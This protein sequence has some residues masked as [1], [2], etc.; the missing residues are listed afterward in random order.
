MALAWDRHGARSLPETAAVFAGSCAADHDA[1]R[2]CV[3]KHCALRKRQFHEV[4]HCGLVVCRATCPDG[5]KRGITSLCSRNA[6]VAEQLTLDQRVASASRC[7]TNDGVPSELP[8]IAILAG[9]RLEPPVAGNYS[10]YRQLSEATSMERIPLAH[11]TLY[12]EL[13]Q[14]ALHAGFD[15]Q[16]PENGSF[17]TKTRKGRKYWYYEGYETTS[18]GVTEARKYSKYVGPQ[19]DPEIAGRVETFG[20]TKASFRER[21]ALVMSLRDA[22]LPTPRA[23]VGDVVEAF[24]KAGLFRL[25]GVLVGTLAYQTYA[26]LLGVRLPAAAVMTGDVD[27]AQSHSVSMLVEDTIPPVLETLQAVDKTFRERPHLGKGAAPAYVND[28]NFSVE[29]LTPNRGG[30]EHAG[31]PARMPALGGASAQPLRYLD[32][33][34]ANPVRAVLLHKGGVLVTVPAPE[35]F[36]VHK[37]IVTVLRKDDPNDLIKARK[38]ALQAGL[39]IEALALNSRQADLGF[40]WMEAWE[41]GPRWRANLAEGCK[42]LGSEQADLLHAAVEEACRHENKR[43]TGYGFAKRQDSKRRAE[44][45]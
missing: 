44:D 24:W 33:L 31:A 16:F 12:A 11:Q 32:F 19:D 29:F 9:N 14:Q 38:D 36:A 43:P 25:R 8:V 7:Q 30:D 27:L 40:T 41:R 1:Q 15:D 45:S 5:S 39:L 2:R 17:V 4:S 6:Q 22:G 21:R 18:G 10:F 37:L 35:R 28:S 42:R 26:G 34:I 3:G 13:Q 23:L 20:R